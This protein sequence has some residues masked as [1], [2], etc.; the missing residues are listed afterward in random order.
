MTGPQILNVW[1][2]RTCLAF[3]VRQC[4]YM[5]LP[6]CTESEEPCLL[7]GE[8]VACGFCTMLVTSLTSWQYVEVVV[9]FGTPWC[10][11]L[12]SM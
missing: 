10:R 12:K 4:T 5:F 9:V 7:T 2:W 6:V 3:S 11:S 8:L 1:L